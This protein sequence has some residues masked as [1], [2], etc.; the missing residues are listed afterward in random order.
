MQRLLKKRNF[1]FLTQAV[2]AGIFQKRRRVE[3]E[4]LEGGGVERIA[5][6][7]G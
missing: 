2:T 6:K 1:L 4:K 3:Q 7:R 5:R